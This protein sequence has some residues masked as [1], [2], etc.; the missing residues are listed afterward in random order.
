MSD[1]IIEEVD[2]RLEKDPIESRNSN[3]N[4]IYNELSSMTREVSKF[5][6]KMKHNEKE[7]QNSR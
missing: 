5:M 7:T 2:E 6:S 4:S 3:M 1:R